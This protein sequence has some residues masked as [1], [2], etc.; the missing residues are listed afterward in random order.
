MTGPELTGHSVPDQVRAELNLIRMNVQGVHGSLVATNDGFLVSHDVADFEPAKLA[1][2][3]ATTRALA[4]SG[5]AS[6]G[7]GQFQEALFHGSDGY[8]AVY[9]AGENAIIGVIGTPDLNV[10]LLNYHV[11]GITGRIASYALGAGGWAGAARPATP[12]T[13]D[14]PAQRP[15]GDPPSPR[16]AL[17]PRRRPP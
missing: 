8:L 7:R 2:L 15:A 9:A 1:A 17:P 16:T 10:G 13:G 14:P 6:A 4:N 12:L 3:A 5:T 11:R